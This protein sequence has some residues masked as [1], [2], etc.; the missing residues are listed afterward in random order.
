MIMRIVCEFD[1]LADFLDDKPTEI[2]RS[3]SL[4][5]LPETSGTLLV[6]H[7]VNGKRHSKYAWNNQ[8]ACSGA[9]SQPDTVFFTLCLCDFIRWASVEDLLQC[10]LWEYVNFISMTWLLYFWG[11][12]WNDNIFRERT[13]PV[14]SKNSGDNW[15]CFRTHRGCAHLKIKIKDFLKILLSQKT[16]KISHLERLLP[17]ESNR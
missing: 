13:F 15:S 3:E 7:S 16:Y 14:V 6:R 11:V 1:K 8:Q 4:R 17:A 10:H 9:V 2:R 5:F 12:F